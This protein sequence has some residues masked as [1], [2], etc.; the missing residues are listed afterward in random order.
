MPSGSFSSPTLSTHRLDL[1]RDIPFDPVRILVG[2]SLPD[3]QEFF[4]RFSRSDSMLFTSAGR[5]FDDT[6]R[7]R[8]HPALTRN[9]H[10]D[11]P[12]FRPT[13]WHLPVQRAAILP[14]A[15]SAVALDSS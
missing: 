6:H 5:S 9:R 7:I 13:G 3:C 2:V 1:C 10:H 4:Q 14:D 8:E 11:G 12:R 15:A